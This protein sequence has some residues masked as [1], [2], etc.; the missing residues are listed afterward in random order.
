M[1]KLSIA[2]VVLIILVVAVFGVIGEASGQNPSTPDGQVVLLQEV[3][4]ENMREI[5]SDSGENSIDNSIL[6]GFIDSP[7]ATCYQPDRRVDECYIN[8]YYMSVSAAPATYMIW[9]EVEI[10]GQK[11]SRTSGFF[12]S[13]MYIP[14]NMLGNG[15]RVSCGALN[16]GG[17]PE[18]GN[19]YTYTIRARDSND[20]NSTNYGAVLCPA[21]IP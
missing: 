12:Q 16:S 5:T 8:W 20:Q 19:I 18:F 15:F 14:D 17:N 11:V 7:T 6:I 1:G 10:N 9:L 3:E 4:G 2:S 13:S 21:Y